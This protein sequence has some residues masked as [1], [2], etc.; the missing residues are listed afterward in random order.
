MLDMRC[1][2]RFASVCREGGTI[3]GTSLTGTVVV[4][5]AA[6]PGWPVVK[7][8]VS[9]RHENVGKSS[10]HSPTLVLPASYALGNALL[11]QLS[12]VKPA[13]LHSRR[14]T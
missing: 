8:A 6:A 10:E 3:T 5:P 4:D 7:R 11:G 1:L 13:S 9:T 12:G 2:K 14:Q